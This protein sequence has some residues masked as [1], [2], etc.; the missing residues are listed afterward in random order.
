MSPGTPNCPPLPPSPSTTSTSSI[1]NDD[2]LSRAAALSASLLTGFTQNLSNTRDLQSRLATLNESESPARL[3]SLNQKNS[4]RKACETD[5]GKVWEDIRR[6]EEDVQ[7]LTLAKARQVALPP[8]DPGMPYKCKSQPIA[9][10]P[11][12]N[13]TPEPQSLPSKA[14][15]NDSSDDSDSTNATDSKS[16]QEIDLGSFRSLPLPEWLGSFRFIGQLQPNATRATVTEIQCLQPNCTWSTTRSKSTD[17]VNHYNHGHE[18]HSLNVTKLEYRRYTSILER[19]FLLDQ[20][21]AWAA[22]LGRPRTRHFKSGRELEEREKAGIR[23][24]SKELTPFPTIWVSPL[25]L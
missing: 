7:A 5:G 8:R 4:R 22:T 25:Q 12:Q 14:A 1:D 16:P 15:V 17:V 11:P 23:F 20:H 24:T 9:P 2:V 19:F 21:V 10:S 3:G 18:D 13:P 6:L